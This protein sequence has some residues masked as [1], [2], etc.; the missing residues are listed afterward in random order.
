MKPVALLA[1][2]AL[3]ALGRGARASYVGEV[4]EA[5]PSAVQLEALGALARID[6][7][8]LCAEAGDRATGLLA[9][10][11]RDLSEQLEAL[12]PDFRRQRLFVC[13]GTSA[14]AMQS[15]QRALAD[16]EGARESLARQANYHAPLD[17]LFAELGLER[18]QVE[19]VQVLGACASSTLALGLACRALDEGACD[20]A[21]AGGY[22]ALSEF[23]VAGFSGLGALSRRGPAPFRLD[24]DGLALGEG[25]GLVALVRDSG[26]GRLPSV[27]GFGASADAVHVTAPDR[28][29]R[30]LARAASRALCDA[31]ARPSDVGLISAHATATPYNDAAESRALALVFSESR[32][33]VHPWKAAIGHTL[34]AA[35]VLESLAAWDALGRD[36]LPAARGAGPTE[37]GLVAELLERNESGKAGCALKLSAAFGG[38]NAALLLGAPG[39]AWAAPERAQRGVELALLGEEIHAGDAQLVASVAPSATELAARADSLSELVLAAVARLVRRLAAPLPESCAVIVG[40]A[41]ATIE[42]NDRFDQ[43]RRAELAVLPRAFP[44]TSPNLC[45]GVCSI[46]FGLRGPAF[47]VGASRDGAA[48]EAFGTAALL[49]AAGDAEAALVVVAEDAGPVAQQLLRRAGEPPLRRRARAALLLPK[50]LKGAAFEAN[51]RRSA[52]ARWAELATAEG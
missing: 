26:D 22:D 33:V 5:P 51:W 43:R 52:A 41:L 12:V 20:L 3:S 28:E 7:R 13:V 42:A 48:E 23:V 16:L 29:G 19:C 24:R 36:V 50:E 30:G 2:A 4:G 1:S 37:P 10:V 49:V 17:A 47:S 31:G 40:S 11:A 25:A 18:T 34:G 6:E 46:A 44:P 32:L 39:T 35:G 14:G 21:I 45:A 9:S 27:L 38:L 15:M 8:L